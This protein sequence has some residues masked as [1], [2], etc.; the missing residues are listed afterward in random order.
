[1][2]SLFAHSNARN[3]MERFGVRAEY[4]T[5]LFQDQWWYES[6]SVTTPFAE[7]LKRYV[8][9]GGS[10]FRIVSMCEREYAHGL[11]MIERAIRSTATV[12][13][14]LTALRDAEAN[15]IPFI[16]FAHGFDD[17]YT[18]WLE[19]EVPKYI[20]GDIT[21]YIGDVTLPNKLTAIGRMEQA[22]RRGVDPSKIVHEFGWMK[23]RNGFSGEF[24]IA[25][26][27][28][29]QRQIMRKQKPAHHREVVPNKL[30]ALVYQAREV[31]Y[32]RTLRTDAVLEILMRSRPIILETAAHFGMSFH[33]VASHSI[34]DLIL[35]NVTPYPT[36]YFATDGYDFAFYHSPLITQQRRIMTSVKGTIA[37]AGTIRGR[38]CVVKNAEEGAKVR[39]GDILVAPMTF[40][41]LIMAMQRAAAFVTDEG[42]LTCHAAIVARE[43]HKPCIVGTKHAT[44]TLKDGDMVEVDANKGIVTKI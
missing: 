5:C 13:E 6:P 44:Q 24:T 8:K 39:K 12:H 1:M 15:V 35:N 11:K 2:I 43:M 21:K 27:R 23:S 31:V 32:L 17:V 30:R 25:E 16:W 42:G 19:R 28:K 36:T 7:Q 14:K 26:V 3:T 20:Q 22:M 9:N 29:E 10:V 38:V 40:P 4:R 18:E 37:F 41:S 34:H 33:E